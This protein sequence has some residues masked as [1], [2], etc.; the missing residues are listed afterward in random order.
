MTLLNEKIKMIAPLL[1][2]FIVF[3][4]T[5]K[6]NILFKPNNKLREYGIGYDNE[7]YKKSLYNLQLIIVIMI[8]IFYMKYHK[9]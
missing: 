3:V 1:I 8:L 9:L 6:P 2:I 5:V 4:Y 7:G